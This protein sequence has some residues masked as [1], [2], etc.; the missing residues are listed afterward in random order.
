[1]TLMTSC[2]VVVKTLEDG[3]GW[4][5]PFD[6]ICYTARGEYREIFR[7]YLCKTTY[8][9]TSKFIS[10]YSKLQDAGTLNH[11]VDGILQLLIICQILLKIMNSQEKKYLKDK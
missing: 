6:Y 3:C 5:T 11:E 10:I 2:D 8:S 1:M 9:S 4:Y 7:Q